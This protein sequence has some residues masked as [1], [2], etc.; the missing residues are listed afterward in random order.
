G[1]AVTGFTGST[2]TERDTATAR[3]ARADAASL[4]AAARARPA[5]ASA[6]AVLTGTLGP[7]V[8]RRSG[9]MAVNGTL[10]LDARGD[11]SAV[12]VLVSDTL[13]VRPAARVVLA[14]GASARNVFWVA[15]GQVTLGT[16][17]S[18]VGTHVTQG[19]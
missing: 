7:G 2:L 14:G 19:A 11:S 1:T 4:H 15:T 18:T 5:T 12:F 16:G 3:A 9:A 10:T 6:P 13:A 8:H 17:S